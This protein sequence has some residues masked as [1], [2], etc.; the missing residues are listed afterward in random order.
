MT[1]L[2]PQKIIP[3]AEIM[4]EDYI[5]HDEIQRMTYSANDDE[6]RSQPQMIYNKKDERDFM[7]KIFKKIKD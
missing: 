6:E 5:A 7:F 1:P 4:N 3:V 2:P